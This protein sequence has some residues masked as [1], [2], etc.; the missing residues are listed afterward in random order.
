MSAAVAVGELRSALTVA[1]LTAR[2]AARSGAV[3]GL[4]FGALIFNEA[5]SYHTSN[6]TAA[7][8]EDIVRT[9]GDN[10]AFAALIGPAHRLD[11]VGGWISWRLLWLLLLVGAIWGC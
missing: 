5:V 9:F 8:R 6:P 1:T 10:A 11:T 2:R 7:S 4:L 3:W